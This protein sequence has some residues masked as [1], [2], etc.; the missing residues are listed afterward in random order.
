MRRVLVAIG[1]GVVLSAGGCRSV[2]AQQQRGVDGASDRIAMMDERFVGTWPDNPRGTAWIADGG[3][4]LYARTPDRFV[5]IR[6]PIGDVPRD[7]LVSGTFHKVSGPP[8]GGYGLIFGDQGVGAGDGLDQGGQF[9]VAEVGD[10][11]EV[12]I[13]RRDGLRWLD[14]VPWTATPAVR[15]DTGRNDLA[16]QVIDDRLVFLVNGRRVVDFAVA[17]IPPAGRVGLFTGGDLNQVVVEHFQVQKAERVASPSQS[18]SPSTGISTRSSVRPASAPAQQPPR[19]QS[20]SPQV[21]GV[22]RPGVSLPG[23]QRVGE[24]LGSIANDIAAIFASFSNGIDSPESPVND[25]TALRE[26]RARLDS[27]TRTATDLA[28]ELDKM[29]IHVGGADGGR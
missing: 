7:V 22:P 2:A 6:A 12:G 27:A 15:T 13:W 5:A 14:V 25:P 9:V 28:A 10:R 16:I 24:L 3:Y 8:G 19:V 1:L 18:T 20:P 17:D 23:L 21:D 4:E 29:G 26:A 11:G